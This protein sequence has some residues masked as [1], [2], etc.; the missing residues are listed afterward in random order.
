[1]LY[2]FMS[3][4]GEW[5]AEREVAVVRKFKD[6]LVRLLTALVAWFFRLTRSDKSQHRGL[7]AVVAADYTLSGRRLPQ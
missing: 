2:D 5:L 6:E 3:K 7:V 1:M 4:S